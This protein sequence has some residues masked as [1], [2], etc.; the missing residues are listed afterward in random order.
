MD[1][2]PLVSVDDRLGQVVEAEALAALEELHPASVSLIYVDPP[3]GTGQTQR[4]N[5]IKTGLGEKTRGGFGG[6]TYRFEVTSSHAYRVIS[7]WPSTWDPCVGT[8]SR[9]IAS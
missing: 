4:L 6:K 9:R 3:F 2:A 7:R 5:S 8:W 1:A